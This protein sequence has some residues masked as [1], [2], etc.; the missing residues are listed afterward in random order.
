MR[1]D[2]VMLMA[3]LRSRDAFGHDDD[4]HSQQRVA[5]PMKQRI[6][7]RRVTEH[8]ATGRVDGAQE[9]PDEGVGQGVLRGADGRRVVAD[10]DY[11]GGGMGGDVS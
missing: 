8:V 6:E 4:G 3:G 9:G 5:C 11:M 10:G 2:S 7:R 1:R